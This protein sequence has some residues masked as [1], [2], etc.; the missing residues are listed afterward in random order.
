MSFHTQQ[1]YEHKYQGVFVSPLDYDLTCSSASLGNL[2]QKY[3][4]PITEEQKESMERINK[5]EQ[6]GGIQEQLEPI[7]YQEIMKLISNEFS[8]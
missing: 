3:G 8:N 5:L 4:G 6:L 2:I 1:F 7:T